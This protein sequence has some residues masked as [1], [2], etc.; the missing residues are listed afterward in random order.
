MRESSGEPAGRHKGR[1]GK[2]AQAE[3]IPVVVGGSELYA[4]VSKVVRRSQPRV[5]GRRAGWCARCR[6]GKAGSRTRYAME[7][8]AVVVQAGSGVARWC[9]RQ[10]AGGI[11]D[12]QNRLVLV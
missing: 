6:R 4:V 3:G 9:G 12:R 1:P 11:P 10:E 2:G 7:P 5:A 8:Q